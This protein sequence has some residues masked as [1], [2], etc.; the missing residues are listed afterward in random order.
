MKRNSLILIVALFFSLFASCTKEDKIHPI[1]NNESDISGFLTIGNGQSHLIQS[2]FA[3]RN[4]AGMRNYI[5]FVNN[6]VSVDIVFPSFPYENQQFNVS[7]GNLFANLCI[8]NGDHV[9]VVDGMFAIE[10]KDDCIYFK[11]KGI[12]QSDDSITLVYHGEV[13]DAMKPSGIGDVVLSGLS[14]PLQ[15]AYLSNN[16]GTYRYI[17]CDMERSNQVGINCSKKLTQGQ[18]SFTNS[19]SD[20]ID[21]VIYRLNEVPVVRYVNRGELT[22]YKT[23]D[24]LAVFMN[25]ELED[26]VTI[27]SSFT[28]KVLPYGIVD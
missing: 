11:L 12:L 17:F 16:N 28:G 7:D 13:Q 15:L 6:S 27:T 4:S 5:F 22:I 1:F 18:Y 23:D 3:Q 25:G 20:S 14:H 8:G 2:V 9:P 19:E 26:G 21:F 10:K 24:G